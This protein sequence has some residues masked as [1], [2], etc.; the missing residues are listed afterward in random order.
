MKE[1]G[2]LSEQD[3][4]LVTAIY[5]ASLNYVDRQLGKLFRSLKELRIWDDLLIIITADH[6]EELLEKGRFGHGDEGE[7]TSFS[8]EL[9]H[10]PLI[11]K[12]PGRAY[13]G[14]CVDG[15][16][17]QVD[18]APTILD[19]LKLEKPSN[20]YGVSTIP[21]LEG[22]RHQIRQEAITQ[23]GIERS[24]A[25]CWRTEQWKFVYNAFTGE[26][27][28][29][30]VGK[31]SGSEEDVSHIYQNVVGELREAVIEHLRSHEKVYSKERLANIEIDGELKKQLEDLGYL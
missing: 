24:F 12:L 17:S 1:P 14:T 8:E 19:I 26:E 5:D 9:I 21:L 2:R 28:L 31:K 10:I 30:E 11:L 3:K 29:Y 6:G 27:R 18:I 22:T 16:V 7:E 13:A 4:E 20:W 15:L 25:M 23:R